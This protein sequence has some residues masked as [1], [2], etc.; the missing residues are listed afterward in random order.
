MK[1]QRGG[2]RAGAGAPQKHVGGRVAKN[3]SLGEAH[4]KLISWWREAHGLP[5]DSAAVA[6]MIESAVFPDRRAGGRTPDPPPRVLALV[7]E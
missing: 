1:R 4:L 3:V 7:G 5:S 6:E 2:R